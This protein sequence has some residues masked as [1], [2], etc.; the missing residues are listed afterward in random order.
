MYLG[1]M[2]SAWPWTAAQDDILL[3]DSS[4]AS[5]S[6]HVMEYVSDEIQNPVSQADLKLLVAASS[7]GI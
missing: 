6:S 7:S 5:Y 1:H 3:I 2:L 4:H